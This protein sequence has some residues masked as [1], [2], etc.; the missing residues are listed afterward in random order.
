MKPDVHPGAKINDVVATDRGFVLVTNCRCVKPHGTPAEYQEAH[1][2]AGCEM[3]PSEGIVFTMY[4]GQVTG[5]EGQDIFGLKYEPALPAT[6]ANVMHQYR[7]A[8]DRMEKQRKRRP[9]P[10][11]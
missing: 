4:A 10:V 9:R 3:H 8:L 6:A 7:T 11:W 2:D 1:K 5:W